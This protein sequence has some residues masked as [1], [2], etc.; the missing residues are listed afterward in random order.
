MSVRNITPFLREAV[1]PAL[2]RNRNVLVI[3]H[4]SPLASPGLEGSLVRKFT[5]WRG[6]KRVLVGDLAYPRTTD[7]GNRTCLII[8]PLLR[9]PSA[10]MP[11]LSD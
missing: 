6:V 7:M 5:E 10:P 8:M 3:G 2:H 1:P 4:G 11:L 9:T